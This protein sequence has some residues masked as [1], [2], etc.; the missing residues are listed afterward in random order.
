MTRENAVIIWG[1]SMTREN[2]VVKKLSKLT[3]RK[4]FSE[5][6]FSTGFLSR[7]TI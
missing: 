7:S 2:S 3:G 5:S 6:T 1:V 4:L